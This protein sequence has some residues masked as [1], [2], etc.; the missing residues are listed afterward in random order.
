M[1]SIRKA[2]RY[3]NA[4]AACGGVALVLLGTIDSAKACEQKPEVVSYVV[5]NDNGTALEMGIDY[6]DNLD[7]EL[8]HPQYC[9]E[10]GRYSETDGYLLRWVE[11]D[12][13][14]INEVPRDKVW[15]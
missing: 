8:D 2:Q 12:G 14:P 11:C 13:V 3:V 4:F 5:T 15:S 6:Q 1:F 9:E 7:Y 10:L